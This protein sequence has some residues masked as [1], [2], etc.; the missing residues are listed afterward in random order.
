MANDNMTKHPFVD[1]M[2]YKF[3]N[4]NKTADQMYYF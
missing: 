3:I 1:L 2:K 4:T